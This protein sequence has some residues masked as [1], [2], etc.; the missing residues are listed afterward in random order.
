MVQASNNNNNIVLNTIARQ[1]SLNTGDLSTSTSGG[2]YQTVNSAGKQVGGVDAANYALSQSP[3]QYV[4]QMVAATLAQAKGVFGGSGVPEELTSVLAN[5]AGY[6]SQQTGTPVA[7]LF[8]KGVLMKDFMGTI[9]SIRNP[10]SQI[11]YVGINTNPLWTNNPTLGP[12]I[13]AA[14]EGKI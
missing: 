6:Y 7:N 4:A 1:T 9:N 13:S 12:T 8:K 14:L 3:A 5:M 10:T 11:G 2:G